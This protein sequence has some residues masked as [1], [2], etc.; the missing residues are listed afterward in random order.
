MR[1]TQ[2]FKLAL[3][4][5]ALLTLAMVGCK[6]D[7]GGP[8][9]G[10]GKTDT[11]TKPPTEGGPIE[12]KGVATIKG[13]FVYDGEPPKAEDLTSQIDP[14]QH[15]GCLKEDPK[16]P[17]PTKGRLWLVSKDGGV[18]NVAVW[19]R[20]PAGKWFKFTDADKSSWPKEVAVD[21]PFCHFEPRV[22]VS[23]YSYKEGKKTIETG[24]KVLALNSAD[25]THNTKYEGD[26]RE[27]PGENLTLPAG[28]KKTLNVK[29]DWETPVSLSCQIHGWMRGYIWVLE[30]PY[31]TVSKDDGTFEIKN[32][33]AGTELMLV[34]WHE[35]AGFG[36]GGSK[37]QVTKIK[38]GDNDLGTIKIKAATPK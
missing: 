21:Q 19:L 24:Q 33:P 25:F 26:K 20:P 27:V 8:T 12:G 29:A 34:T 32:V 11:G 2:W 5:P 31:A 17:N 14:K 13:K 7:N 22:S 15:G 4:A 30:T 9:G 6:K 35:G 28:D 38:E 3:V 10:A 1:T 36:N 16:N 37:G 18:Q 23:F